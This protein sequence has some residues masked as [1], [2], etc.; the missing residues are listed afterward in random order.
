MG[1]WGWEWGCGTILLQDKQ[2]QLYCVTCQELD[3]APSPPPLQP[4]APRPEHC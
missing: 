1:L 3:S 2:Q 4:A